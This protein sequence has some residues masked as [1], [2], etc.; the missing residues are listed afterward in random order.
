MEFLH[1]IDIRLLG[2]ALLVLAGIASS[3]LARRFGAPLLLVFLAL[4]LLL[5]V[6]GPGGIRYDDT[7]FTYFVGSL[8]LCVILFDG[9]LQTRAAQVRG[10]VAPSLVLATVGVALTAA[11]TGMAAHWF[12]QLPLLQSLL[13]G[14]VL[15][16]TDAAAVLFLLRAG[17]LHLERR[18]ASTL[19]MESGANDP[20]AIFLTVGLT[21]WLVAGDAQQGGVVALAIRMVWAMAAG[22]AFG[23][24]GGRLLVWALNRFA[25]PSGLPPWLAM[26]GA[27]ALFAIANHAGGSG[28]LAVYLAGIVVA[29][30]P[31]RARGEIM[32][33][34]NATTWFAQL[35]M[36]LLLG[37]LAAPRQLLGVLWP[38]LAVAASLMLVARPLAV[39]LCLAPF[40][41]RAGEIGF[42][43]WVGLR[44]AVSIF[45]ASIPLLA[46]LPNAGLYF[47]VAFV[48]V[49]AS[50]L[51]QGWS[52]ARAAHLFGV[53]V[54]RTDPDTRRIQLDLP[55]QLE[56]DLVGYR[57]APG[58]AALHGAALPG[59]VRLAML[60]RE[61]QV[62][63]PEQA[64][65]FIANDY[66][67][68]LSPA[69]QAH[70]LDWLFAEGRAARAA[71]QETFGLFLLPGDVPLGE[72][73][74]FYGL[75]LPPRFAA[76]TAADLFDQR[77]DGTPQVGDRLSLGRAMLVARAVRED[78]VE[79]VGLKFTGLGERLISGGDRR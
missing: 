23:Y 75:K 6:D 50:L 62:L 63:L 10:S 7:R 21:T 4:G 65:N 18:T 13:L 51:V 27:V 36:F 16:S 67:Y 45:L 74:Q 1:A 47:N 43:G 54:P 77:F 44:G 57:I 15:A 69:G 52:L 53:A 56:Y 32:S 33:V 17:G 19:E 25:L 38:A 26:A 37:L 59:R 46:Q 72:L 73:A 64:A 31:L 20:V 2:G 79:R 14:S 58:S 29:N 5:G 61:G 24:A 40:R 78:R 34:Q 71:E 49:L 8:A 60:V 66:A 70:R 39:L 41:Y 28:Y 76:I 48:V 12:L 42:I 35:V 11:M 9:G 55:G 22:T 3:L 68:F 30:R